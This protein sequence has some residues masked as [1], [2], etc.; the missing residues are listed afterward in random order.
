M[1]CT[2]D[3]DDGA[4]RSI[5]EKTLHSKTKNIISLYYIIEHERS[6]VSNTRNNFLLVRMKNIG[7]HNNTRRR[8]TNTR[9]RFI[10]TRR[11]R[12]RIINYR[13]VVWARRASWYIRRL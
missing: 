8:I 10:N 7:T 13:L 1:R 12:R 2:T 4:E 5:D 6:D 9:R 11:R 3:Y